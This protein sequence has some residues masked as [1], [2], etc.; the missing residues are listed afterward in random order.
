MCGRYSLSTPADLVAEVFDLEESFELEPRYNIA[1]TQEAAIVRTDRGGARTAAM[2]RWGLVPWWAK[3]P[4]FGH[5]AINAR[6]ETVH[7]SRAFRNPF[8]ERRCLVPA[9]G[10]YEWQRRGGQKQ[11]FHLTLADGTPFAFAGLY[12]LWR[13]AEGEWIESFTILTTVPN[14]LLEPIHDRMPVILPAESHPLWLDRGVSDVDRLKALLAPYPTERM[15]ATPV[16]HFVNNPRNEGPRCV[17]EVDM[18]PE[19]R[20]LSL[21]D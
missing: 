15:L 12:D 11:P 18:P 16:G 10:F 20:N 3:D 21:W 19:P 9:D 7:E 17:E 13:R 14:S 2:A 5:R 8:R 1:P 4:S 6:A